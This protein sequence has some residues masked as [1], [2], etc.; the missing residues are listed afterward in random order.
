MR[1]QRSR[2]TQ[3]TPA[4]QLPTVP[5]QL[6][7]AGRIPDRLDYMPKSPW[8]VN[9]STACQFILVTLPTTRKQIHFAMCASRS[10]KS[11]NLR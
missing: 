9:P 11:D 4:G 3:T 6:A 8:T 5:V 7:G 2:L 10:K 1:R